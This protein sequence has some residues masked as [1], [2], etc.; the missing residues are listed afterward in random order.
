[1]NGKF[2]DAET[3]MTPAVP[4]PA[5]ADL[6][7]PMDA[8]THLNQMLDLKLVTVIIKKQKIQYSIVHFKDFND[9]WMM[10]EVENLSGIAH[11]EDLVILVQKITPL[12]IYITGAIKNPPTFT[13]N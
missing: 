13:A 6:Q 10:C 7:L 1:M 11:G 3:M 5:T 4:A 12:T 9:E 8:Y 2:H